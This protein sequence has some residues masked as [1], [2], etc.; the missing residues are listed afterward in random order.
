MEKRK[1]AGSFPQLCGGRLG[2]GLPCAD[3]VARQAPGRG[4]PPS[5]LPPADGGMRRRVKEQVPSPGSAGEGQDGGSPALTVLLGRRREEEFPHLNLPPSAGEEEKRKGAG[6]FPRLCGGRTGWGSPALTVLLG[7]RRE[8]EFPHLLFP[9]PRGK[10]RRGKEQVP[11]PGSAGEGQDGG[12]P[13]LTVLLGRRREEEFPHLN[14]PPR[15]GEE[16]KRREGGCPWSRDST[17]PGSWSR[18]ST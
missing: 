9:R 5:P 14:L 3:R 6:S 18:T 4:V 13:A 15:T 2:W 12:F 1:G 11:S 7:R 16:E 10:R 17:T 8:E